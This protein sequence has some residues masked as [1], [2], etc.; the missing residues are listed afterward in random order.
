MELLFGNIS[1]WHWLILGLLLIIVELFIWSVYCLWLGVSAVTIAILINLY[2]NLS[3][4]DQ[5]LSFVGLSAVTIF[6]GKKILPVKTID[7]KLQNNAKK[8]IGKMAEVIAVEDG[9]A[10]IK[11]GNSVWQ[12]KGCEM[13]IGQGVRVVDAKALTLIVEDES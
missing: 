11:V 2:P 7:E 4:G 12:A 8:H 10:K 6:V 5:V 9:F 13:T 3:L 1:D